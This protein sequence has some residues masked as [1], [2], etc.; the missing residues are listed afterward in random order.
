MLFN[1]GLSNRIKTKRYC[2]AISLKITCSKL[3]TT[4]TY[5]VTY[6]QNFRKLIFR[7]I[8]L[9]YSKFV[10]LVHF[11]VYYCLSNLC[12]TTSHYVHGKTKKKTIFS[13]SFITIND[14]IRYHAIYTVYRTLKLILHYVCW[15]CST[16]KRKLFLLFLLV[17]LERI[18]IIIFFLSTFYK[19][20]HSEYSTHVTSLLCQRYS[21]L[22]FNYSKT[23]HCE[24]QKLYFD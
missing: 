20:Y 24:N 18:I 2:T 9:W 1:I 6:I 17:L 5:I 23:K 22:L 14:H 16:T 4:Y 19:F 7:W 8:N 11:K 21:F 10:F 13:C 12:F 15:L 3:K